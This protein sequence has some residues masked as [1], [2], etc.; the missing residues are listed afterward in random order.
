M[1]YWLGWFLS[2]IFYGV[3]WAPRLI[4]RE[5]IPDGPFLLCPTHRSWF[6]PPLAGSRFGRPIAYMA[7]RELFE[8][9][10]AGWILRRVHAVPVRR[11]G[12]DRA[13][14][15]H[16]LG[17]L[18]QGIPVLVFP[19][20]T[21]SRTGQMLPPRPGIGFLAHQA[22]VPLVPAYIDGTFRLKRILFRWGR[23]TVR[24][25]APISPD[26]IAAHPDNKEGYRAISWLV[27][28]RICDLGD[29]PERLWAEAHGGGESQ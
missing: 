1:L 7:K 11:G 22:G 20:G 8:F 15:G 5:H 12:V 17:K 24:L 23:L 27:M 21:R 28:R 16:V 9:P 18:E 2:K 3:F 4:G 10:V 26:E 19:E 29:D 14:I 13:A 25:G 6:D